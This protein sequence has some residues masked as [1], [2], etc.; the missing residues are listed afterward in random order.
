M[1]R[2]F[3]IWWNCF[4]F[5]NVCFTCSSTKQPSHCIPI[6][7][8]PSCSISS[9]LT[10]TCSSTSN[11]V[12]HMSSGLPVLALV[13]K[14]FPVSILLSAAELTWNITQ[15]LPLAQIPTIHKIL[16]LKCVDA[17]QPKGLAWTVR[18]HRQ[19]FQLAK[20]V[21]LPNA[22]P[23]TCLHCQKRCIFTEG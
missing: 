20:L 8:F 2:I 3:T 16:C 6:S 18:R 21:Q 17:V 15:L 10:P 4:F 9:N 7:T 13:S 1:Y 5:L 12:L 19:Q 22:A 23:K 14:T 11:K